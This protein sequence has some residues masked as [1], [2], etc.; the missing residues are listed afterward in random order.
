MSVLAGRQFFSTEGADL[1]TMA[2]KVALNTGMTDAAVSLVPLTQ[3][4][5]AL[6]DRE[7][8]GQGVPVSHR[9]GDALW[10]RL[11]SALAP[12]AGVPE[13]A[14]AIG[15]LPVDSSPPSSSSRTLLVVGALAL[16]GIA[17]YF[18]VKD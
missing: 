9:Q 7:A 12:V 10:T 6:A 2:S 11:D 14:Q 17:A 3:E 5:N 16:A 1:A 8:N 4:L 15:R 18:Y 13:V